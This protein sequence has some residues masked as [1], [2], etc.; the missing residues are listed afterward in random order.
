MND[1]QEGQGQAENPLDLESWEETP[2]LHTP[3]LDAQL[4]DQATRLTFYFASGHQELIER[5]DIEKL[6]RFLVRYAQ[7]APLRGEEGAFDGV[8]FR[9]VEE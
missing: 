4:A 5:G 8:S 6:T 1:R 2:S 3:T 9:Q 7:V